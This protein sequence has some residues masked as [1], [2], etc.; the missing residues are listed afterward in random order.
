MA[1]AK[2]L[3]ANVYYFCY[4]SK[5]MLVRPLNLGLH[6]TVGVEHRWTARATVSATPMTVTVLVTSTKFSGERLQSY[7]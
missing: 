6:H 1:K 2:Y 7:C 4:F 5:K 3:K